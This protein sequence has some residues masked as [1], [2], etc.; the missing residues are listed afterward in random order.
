MGQII[1]ERKVLLVPL[2]KGTVGMETAALLGTLVLSNVWHA[3]LSRTRLPIAARLPVMVYV[4][5]AQDVLRLP[6]DVADMLA[7]ARGLGAGFTLAHQYLG[8]ITDKQVKAALLGTVRSTIAFQC[9]WEDAA[10]LA[11]SYAP[12]LT[13]DDLRGLAAYEI[14]LRPCVDGQT[15]TPVT[16]T[17]LALPPVVLDGDAL[18]S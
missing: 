4:D 14:A 12:H 5:E 18:L 17:T 9:G 16:G 2:G 15:M 8:Q 1:H 3:I 7:Q 11:H 13:A 10:V 6:V